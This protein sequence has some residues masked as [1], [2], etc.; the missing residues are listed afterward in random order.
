M[1]GE[2]TSVESSVVE[3]P[4]IE[5]WPMAFREPPSPHDGRVIPSMRL[6]SGANARAFFRFECEPASALREARSARQK[7]CVPWQ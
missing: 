2:E 3:S 6:I 5:S 7:E 4:H 1:I